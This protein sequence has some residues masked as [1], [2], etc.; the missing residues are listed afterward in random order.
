MIPLIKQVFVGVQGTWWYYEQAMIAQD[1]Q[2]AK[3]IGIDLILLWG[4]QF[5]LTEKWDLFVNQCRKAGMRF[6]LSPVHTDLTHDTR[7]NE[8]N[9]KDVEV[10]V[11]EAA[12]L[13][14]VLASRY[15]PDCWYIDM[16]FETGWP[17][18]RDETGNFIPPEKGIWGDLQKKVIEISLAAKLVNV[19]LSPFYGTY[20]N[21]IP[22]TEIIRYYF[23]IHMRRLASLP[24]S[25]PRI[26]F[27]LA[28]QDGV[29]CNYLTPRRIVGSAAYLDLLE[30][31]KAEKQV[32][33]QYGWK[34]SANCELFD[35]G[36][37]YPPTFDRIKGQLDG[38]ASIGVPIG[39][40]WEYGASLSP[41]SV[42]SQNR[43]LYDAYKAYYEASLGSRKRV[44]LNG[45]ELNDFE[46]TI[47][48]R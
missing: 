21:K 9:V 40:C 16:E 10:S 32:C 43:P 28:L 35:L 48:T 39:P 22:T 12:K 14:P 37:A 15:S 29:G 2:F 23:D 20:D 26:G 45:M 44:V 5:E 8:L 33:E 41:L 36:G 19:F 30:K 46:I 7:P 38:M 47:N 34:F 17:S 6:G 18:L 25:Y 11:Q 13:A 3:D 27:N 24:T 31:F 4:Q 42:F 1:I